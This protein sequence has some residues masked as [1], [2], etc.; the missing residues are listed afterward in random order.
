MSKADGAFLAITKRWVFVTAQADVKLVDVGATQKA[1]VLFAKAVC[2]NANTGDV[3]VDIGL[4]TAT[5]PTITND[6]L[7]GGNGVFLSHPGI[8]HG[9]GEVNANSGQPIAVGAVDEDI[10]LTCSAATGG[11]LRVILQY[12]LLED[13]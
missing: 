7:T 6:S 13:Q 11:A 3:S 2:S 8:A 12:R 9:G 4:A 10:R 5:L 1:S